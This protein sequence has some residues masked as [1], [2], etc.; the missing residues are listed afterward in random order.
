MPSA[1]SSCASWRTAAICATGSTCEADSIAAARPTACGAPQSPL[2]T[3]L[4]DLDL[5]F[6]RIVAR[7]LH[8]PEVKGNKRGRQEG[9]IYLGRHVDQQFFC[10]LQ[11]SPGE[12]LQ[13]GKRGLQPGA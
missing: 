10:L 1:R 9:G 11:L 12:L 6:E 4:R 2:P 5:R 13:L 8:P 7:A 3:P